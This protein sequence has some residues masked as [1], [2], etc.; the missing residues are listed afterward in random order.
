M[1]TKE[2]KALIMEPFKLHKTDTGGTATQVA[3]LTER[4]NE[5]AKHV[6]K[7]PKDYATRIGM[8]KLV[9]QRRRLLNYLQMTDQKRYKDI[10]TQLK[11]RK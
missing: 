6:E 7:N 3:L 10:L 9:G 1:I 11:L 5:L 4:I 2:Q 8:L